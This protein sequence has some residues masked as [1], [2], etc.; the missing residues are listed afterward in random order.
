MT[1]DP[2]LTHKLKR[3]LMKFGVIDRPLGSI[4]GMAMKPEELDRHFEQPLTELESIFL[5]HEGRPIHKWAH[6]LPIYDRLFALYRARPV[7]FLEIGVNRGGSLEMWRRYFGAEA[8]IAGVDIDEVC[9]SRVDPPN[10]VFIG[11]Q[12]DPAFLEDVV[13]R[14][15]RP[16]IVL[17]DG[18][19]V[20]E[21]QRVSFDTLFPLLKDGGLYLIEDIAT[22]YWPD[23]YE[24]GYRRRGTAI[25]F[26]KDF[27][28]DVNA[29]Y[30]KE[31]FD[32][33]IRDHVHS[34]AFY[35]SI[36]AI[37]KKPKLPPRHLFRPPLKS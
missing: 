30:H 37:E 5:G 36:I 23:E 8:V 6:Y 22:A 13:A 16:D 26:A 15:G 28:D 27:V 24:G 32:P 7:T 4:E 3:A 14:V 21:H 2:Y 35:D 17:D 11:S 20:A 33:L 34:I 18:S 12:A 10:Q 9:A 1:D 25:E 19:H 31:H 29:W